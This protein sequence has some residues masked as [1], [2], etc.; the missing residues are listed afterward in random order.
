MKS[1]K[2]CLHTIIRTVGGDGN[3][4]FN[5]GPMLDGRI[6]KRQ[7]D[8]LG[9]MGNWLKLNGETIYGTKGG[10]I[11]PQD[12]GVS[13]SKEDIIYLHILEK[14]DQINID[15]FPGKVAG[16]TMY[17]SGETVPFK[18]K[19]GSLTIDIPV[20]S[21]EVIDLILVVKSK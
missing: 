21:S 18:Q 13:T 11:A 20:Q 5:V 4:L 8:R 9:E 14:Q 19:K 16:I 1:S 2:E 7:V 12:W 6:E 15:D 10:P 3:L 17:Q